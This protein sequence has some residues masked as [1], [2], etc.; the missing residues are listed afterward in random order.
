MPD[1]LS[2]WQDDGEHQHDDSVTSVGIELPGNCHWVRVNEW[3]RDLMMTK[4]ADIFRSKGILCM[5][6]TNEK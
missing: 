4:G 2:F 6:G 1:S 5:D 3:L